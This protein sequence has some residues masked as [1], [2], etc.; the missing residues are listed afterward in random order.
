[1]IFIYSFSSGS[2]GSFFNNTFK[3]MLKIDVSG[4]LL[5]FVSSLPTVSYDVTKDTR[6]YLALIGQALIGVA[7]PFISCV[8]T[9]ISHHW[10]AD[11]QRTLA[12]TLLGLS[13]ITGCFVGSFLTPRFVHKP[14]DITTMNAMWF[15]PAAIG[16]MLTMWKVIE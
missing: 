7:T 5:C 15:F 14:S 10:F 3:C 8:P 9:K 13:G 12:T 2:Q 6:F 16:S 11:E 4:G 1:M